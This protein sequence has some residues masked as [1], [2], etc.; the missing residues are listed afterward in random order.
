MKK[1]IKIIKYAAAVIILAVLVTIVCFRLPDGTLEIIMFDVDQGDGIM[2]RTPDGTVIM[3][4]GGSTGIDELW[5]WRLESALEYEGV[6][7]IDYSIITHP[8]SDH[9]SGILDL[10]EDSSSPVTIDILLIPYVEDSDNYDE[11][12]AAAEEAGVTVIN[13]YAGMSIKAGEVTLK[14]IHP[15]EGDVYEDT[16]D[17]SCTLSLVYGEFLALFTGDIGEEVELEILEEGNLEDDYD[18][19][20]VAHHGSKY[21][22]CQEFLEAVSPKIAIISAGVD[23]SYGHPAEETI[24]RLEEVG[25]EIYVTAEVGEIKITVNKKGEMD[26]WTKL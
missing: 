25:A 13:I 18:L 6:T 3:I 1:N 14:C 12:T 16:N 9:I 24:S 22:S 2:I 17:Y 11:L 5:A 8:D 21:S 23:N 15:D 20:K 4:D 26:I 7:E 19:L 10:L